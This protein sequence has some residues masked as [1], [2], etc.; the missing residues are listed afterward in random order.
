MAG[1]D[2][3][4]RRYEK[5]LRHQ[6]ATVLGQPGAAVPCFDCI[7]LGMGA[8]GHTASLF[9]GRPA[10]EE[11]ERL[12]VAVDAP[13]GKP[14]LPRLS[15]TLPLIN[16]ARMVLFLVAGAD[17]GPAL[18]EIMDSAVPSALPAARV[19]PREEL[20]WLVSDE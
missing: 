2:A 13:G 18:A 4:A 3:A 19:R 7:H 20:R 17:K 16:N 9:P 12:I 15:M 5:H 11:A 1:L 8:D 6:F 14:P 10:L